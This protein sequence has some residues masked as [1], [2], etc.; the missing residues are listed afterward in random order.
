MADDAA[1][2]L[3]ESAPNSPL[4]TVSQ[5]ADPSAHRHDGDLPTGDGTDAVASYTPHCMRVPLTMPEAIWLCT[6]EPT[7]QVGG[8]TDT[9]AFVCRRWAGKP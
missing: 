1:R 9:P 6:D 7:V 2:V 4:L 8:E 3:H 5:C